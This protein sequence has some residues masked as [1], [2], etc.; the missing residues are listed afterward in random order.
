MFR[1][2]SVDD[3][4]TEIKIRGM[5]DIKLKATIFVFSSYFY[6]LFF[7]ITLQVEDLVNFHQSQLTKSRKCTLSGNEIEINICFKI[8]YAKIYR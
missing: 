2:E 5:G 1:S 4:K 3:M 7:S 6:S 8:Y